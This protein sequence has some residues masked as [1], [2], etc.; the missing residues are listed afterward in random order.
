MGAIEEALGDAAVALNEELA[1]A[2]LGSFSARFRV[3]DNSIEALVSG[4]DFIIADPHE[5]PIH[6][7]GMGIQT[8]ALLAAFRWITRQEKKAG[9]EV[10]WLLEETGVI[11]S[12]A[13]SK[14][15]QR[16]I[17]QSLFGFDCCENNA[18]YGIRAPR[19]AIFAWNGTLSRKPY[20]SSRIS[21][22]QRGDWCN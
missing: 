2:E 4:F 20:R 19:S 9:Y 6:E 7:K 3:P 8:T 16:N 14:K 17:E 18:F 12:P 11:S 22:L 15:L 1:L 5:T 21:Y 13:F 10:I